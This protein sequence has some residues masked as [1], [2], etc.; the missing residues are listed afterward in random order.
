M[1][2]FV[3]NAEPRAQFGSRAA[4]LLRQSG[5]V[6]ANIY[7]HK[8]ANV[9]VS[10]DTKEFTKF[11][12]AGHRFVTIRVGKKDEPSVVKEVQ[13]DFLGSSLIHVDFSRISRDEKVEVE[14]PVETIGIP[15]GLSAG[16]VLDFPMKEVLITGFPQDLPER[17]EINIE[18]LELG[19]AIRLKDL[20]VP[21]NCV[22]SGNPELVIVTVVHQKTETPVAPAEGAPVQPEV[23]GK[24]KEE[25][26]EAP[27]EPEAKKK[28]K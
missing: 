28:E 21:A 9:L 3:L 2:Q 15:K 14:V 17:I 24:K 5:R 13:Y 6:P 8:E 7:G 11:L 18:G 25:E 10:L 19:H 26:G 4:E 22:F 12:G 23:I 27:A 20:P 16:G 1:E